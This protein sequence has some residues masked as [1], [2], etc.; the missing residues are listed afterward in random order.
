MQVLYL[1]YLT[2]SLFYGRFP[3]I[4]GFLDPVDDFYNLRVEKNGNKGYRFYSNYSGY[5]INLIVYLAC[6]KP[7]IAS[8]IIV[9]NNFVGHN[10]GGRDF[11]G[12]ARCCYRNDFRVSLISKLI[13]WNFHGVENGNRSV[14]ENPICPTN[15]RVC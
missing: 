10:F 1:F 9:L 2:N 14:S 11:V 6:S 7:S 13:P 4:I 3:Y 12:Y 15:K 5:F 8:L